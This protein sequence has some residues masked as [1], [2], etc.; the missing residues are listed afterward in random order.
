[1]NG[2]HASYVPARHSKH[3]KA[4]CNQVAYYIRLLMREVLPLQKFEQA[5]MMT[6]EELNVI[7]M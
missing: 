5:R 1:M 7:P 4:A 3:L 6:T 2:S